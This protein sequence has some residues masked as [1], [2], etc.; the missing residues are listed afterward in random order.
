MAVLFGTDGVRGLA[1]LEMTAEL[2]MLLAR[3]A[4]AAMASG[5][6]PLRFL[7]AR[8]TRISS[9]RLEAAVLA[10]LCS[11]GA[12]VTSGGVMPTPALAALV[13]ALHFDGGIMVTASH[14]PYQYNGLKFFAR[15]GDK[16]GDQQQADIENATARPLAGTPT[17]R[18]GSADEDHSLIERYANGIRQLHRAGLVGIR[19]IADCG[20]GALCRIAPRLLADMG[21]AVTTLNCSPDGT[22]INVGGVMRPQS[23]VAAVLEQRADAG[24]AFDGDGDRVILVDENGRLVDGDQIIAIWAN[25]LHADGRLTNHAVVGTTISNGGLERCLSSIGCRLVRADVGD[26]HVYATMRECGAILGGETCG[27][28]IHSPHISSADGLLTGAAILSLMA[29][30]GKPLS[31]LANVMQKRPQISTNIPVTPGVDWRSDGVISAAIAQIERDLHDGGW[32]AVRP[33]GTEPVI[34]VTAECDD[35]G[36]SRRVVTWLSSLIQERLA[37]VRGPVHARG[38]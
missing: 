24:I 27:H 15:G 34:R 1:N 37:D 25:A 14:N 3:A 8:D 38:L 9:P 10:G 19:V 36:E 18:L 21:A 31:A 28:I 23:L 30:S 4:P 33:S 17:A 20:H 11:A 12:D 5:A 22:N 26:R 29:R 16:I 35:E 6:S 7:V 2:A 32:L 13:K